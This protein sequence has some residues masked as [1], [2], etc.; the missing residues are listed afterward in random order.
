LGAFLS[1]NFI[2][3]GLVLSILV[4]WFFPGP[5]CVAAAANAQVAATVGIF[6]ISG[7][8]LQR[9]ETAAALRATTALAYGLTAILLRLPLRPPEMALG[10]AVFCCMPTTLSTGIT[11]TVA[12]NGNAAVALLLTVASNMMAVRFDVACLLL[13]VVTPAYH[14]PSASNGDGQSAH[15]CSASS[16]TMQVFSIPLMLSFVLGSSAGVANFQAAQ[17]FRNLLRTVLLPLLVGAAAQAVIPGE[18]ASVRRLPVL[19]A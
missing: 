6:L 5:G 4:G 19:Y 8:L 11:L 12:S 3:C 9:G 10:L 16:H 17:L 14:V 2:P 18:R 15:D 1:S 7:L 13:S